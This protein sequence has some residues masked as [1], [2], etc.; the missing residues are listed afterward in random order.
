MNSLWNDAEAE[1]FVREHGPAFG[2]DIALRTYSARL[3]GGER[4]LVLHGGGNT[5]VKGSLRTL[6]GEAV[7][8]IF[9]KATGAD[10]AS[11]R[12][13]R[14]PPARPG[15]AAA[16]PAAPR[17][18]RW[19]DGAGTARAALR[20]SAATPSIEA[21]VHAFLPAR[22][23]DHT[24]ADAILT[25]TNQPDGARLV[26]EALGDDVIV[27]PYVTPGFKLALA[28]ADALAGRP[29]AR[30]MV[31]CRHGIVTWGET[32][33]GSYEAMI[34]LVTRAERAI[35]RRVS[36]GAR[37][38]EAT[39]PAVAAARVAAVA[40]TLRGLLA[41][42]TGDPDRPHRRVVLLPLTTPET[43]AF[44]DAPGARERALTP[45][46]TSDHLIRTKALPAWVDDPCYEDP[47][48]LREQL[49]AAV[50]DYSKAYQEYLDRHAAAMPEGITPFDPLP[51]VV[52]LPGLGA[53]CA[54]HD[55]PAAVVARDITAQTLAVKARVA[56]FGR[57]EGL[58]EADLFA[59][60][61]RTLQ[62]AK[63]RD[64]S[65]P[66][67]GG[68]ALVTGAAGAIGSGVVPR[69]ARSG[70]PRGGHGPRG[71]AP[72]K[73]GR[74]PGRG[75]RPAD[76]RR[77]ARRDRRAVGGR[78]LPR[79]RRL[80]GRHRPRDRQRGH[81]ARVAARARWSWRRSAGWSA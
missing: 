11:I 43:L 79:G 63:L 46:L 16:P 20:P 53:L 64:A 39:T 55:L 47:A 26:A 60:E 49:A 65:S 31:W 3:L 17:R 34:E 18:R 13:L 40:P 7:P 44:V 38:S 8:A 12:A 22:Y 70:L 9:V 19:R 10:L 14:A 6:G 78:G 45:P 58:P 77:A 56:A 36:A 15:A 71:P 68:V 35:E 52:L 1:R 24:H 30:A 21:L 37:V 32:A 80:L 41:A 27:L 57:Y 48:R 50:G 25:L 66:L 28:A 5:S 73:P 59:M 54:G 81:R 2:E 33:R 4:S 61:Y 67:A 76:R 62:H 74:E 29:S 75:L 42:S 69:L 23:I 51:R 72:R